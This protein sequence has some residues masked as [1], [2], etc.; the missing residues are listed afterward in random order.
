MKTV[1]F[2]HKEVLLTWSELKLYLIF[3]WLL[4]NQVDSDCN[5]FVD[6]EAIPGLKLLDL[7]PIEWLKV[8]TLYVLKDLIFDHD[9][10]FEQ[11]CAPK[12]GNTGH[13]IECRYSPCIPSYGTSLC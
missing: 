5:L 8:L 9:I 4:D 3:V 2:C 1:D 7:F 10:V 13:V 6:F 12:L 11:G